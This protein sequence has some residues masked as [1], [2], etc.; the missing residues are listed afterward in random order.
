LV[1]D[2]TPTVW[3][4]NGDDIGDQVQD[5]LGFAGP[6]WTLDDRDGLGK[7]ILNRPALAE[8]AVER[9][10]RSGGQV[11]LLDRSASQ[12]ATQ[13]A[14]G[15]DEGQLAVRAAHRIVAGLARC[16]GAPVVQNVRGR[17]NLAGRSD[18]A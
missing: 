18:K 6:R 3:A 10:D 17:W 9:E 1:Y 2:T 13:H 8:V 5:G 7:S 4:R 12:V 14:L 15:V 11:M 16:D